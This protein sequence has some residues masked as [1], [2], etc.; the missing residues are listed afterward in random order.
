MHNSDGIFWTDQ[1]LATLYPV[2]ERPLVAI[3][4][5]YIQYLP[6]PNISD[7]NNVYHIVR[8]KQAI[9]FVACRN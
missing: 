5:F 2:Q 7:Y 1:S 9:N 6:C 4:L 3:C 8:D